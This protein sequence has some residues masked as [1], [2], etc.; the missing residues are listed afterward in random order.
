MSN[1]F[2]ILFHK[3]ALEGFD[4][5]L[6]DY[7]SWDEIRDE[8]FHLLRKAFVKAANELESYLDSIERESFDSGWD[9]EDEDD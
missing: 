8:E 4:Y 3:I 9:D 7:S 1:E 5:A 6:R 2:E